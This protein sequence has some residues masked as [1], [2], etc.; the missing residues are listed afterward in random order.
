MPNTDTTVLVSC[1]K[2]K[3]ST[4]CRA[5][6]LYVSTLFKEMRRYAEANGDQW[7]ILSA[8]YGL[9]HPDDL[10]EPYE[11]TLKR[12]L[13]RD[14]EEWAVEVWKRLLPQVQAGSNVVFL[15]GRE[16]RE[17]LMPKMLASGIAVSVPMEG[18]QFGRQ[19]RWLQSRP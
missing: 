4:S 14:R 11:K 10:I 13:K 18:L 8:K 15:A 7:F 9:L 12:M 19:L 17:S 16:Y 5:K 6:D 1:V 3:R 2:S